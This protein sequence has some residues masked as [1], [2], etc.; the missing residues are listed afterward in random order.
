MPTTA[1]CSLGWCADARD[2]QSRALRRQRFRTFCGDSA[3]LSKANFFRRQ[4]PE[5]TTSVNTRLGH[6]KVI[7]TLNEL[8][9]VGSGEYAKYI[10]KAKGKND[11]SVFKEDYSPSTPGMNE[12]C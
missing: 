3:P 4:T 9:R 1:G 6:A 2:R 11:V 12:I 7:E 8:C 5:T 10:V